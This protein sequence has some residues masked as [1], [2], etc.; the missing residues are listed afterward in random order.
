MGGEFGD[1][2]L[3]GNSYEK[4]ASLRNGPLPVMRQRLTESALSRRANIANPRAAAR[5]GCRTGDSRKFRNLGRFS[6]GKVQPS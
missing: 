4:C 6:R 3:A 1:S 5:R 2:L